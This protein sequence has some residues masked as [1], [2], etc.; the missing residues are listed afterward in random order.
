MLPP[1]LWSRRRIALTRPNGRYTL[2]I[3]ACDKKV[4]SILVQ[5][6]PDRPAK[7]VGSLSR[8]LYKAE[9]ASDGKNTKRLSFVWAVLLIC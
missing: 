2:D 5:E 1:R 7:S 4:G 6:L 9:Q 3:D 8:L